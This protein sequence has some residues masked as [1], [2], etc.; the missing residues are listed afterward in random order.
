MAVKHTVLFNFKEDTGEPQ[1]RDA[2]DALNRLPEIISEIQDWEIAEDQ[3][4][5]KG[6]FRFALLATFADM[7]AVERYLV[8][9]EHERAV[10][11]AALLL[12]QVAEHDY[13][14]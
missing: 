7:N 8:H 11:K 12:E 9:P 2:V 4:K 14:I 3:G 13:V 6:S 1:I 10:A 5:R